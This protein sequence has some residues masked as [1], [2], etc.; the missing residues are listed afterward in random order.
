[1]C[2]QFLRLHCPECLVLPGVRLADDPRASV[3]CP[4]KKDYLAAALGTDVGTMRGPMKGLIAARQLP[5]RVSPRPRTGMVPAE[6]VRVAT[7]STHRAFGRLPAGDGV[8][9]GTHRGARGR[10]LAL[11]TGSSDDLLPLNH[12]EI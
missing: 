4:A 2:F 10:W 9:V 7:R 11:L 5:G 3:T 6:A 8:R 1:M 12:G